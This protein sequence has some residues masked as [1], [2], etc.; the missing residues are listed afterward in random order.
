MH[1]EP[2]KNFFYGAGPN[3]YVYHYEL[4]VRTGVLEAEVGSQYEVKA[5]I[6][7]RPGKLLINFAI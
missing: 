4:D 7:I 5:D 6:H 2:L 3:E 1:S